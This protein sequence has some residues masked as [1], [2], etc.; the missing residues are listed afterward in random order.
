MFQR[1]QWKRAT[2]DYPSVLNLIETTSD[3]S[4]LLHALHAYV[5][6]GN[7]HQPVAIQRQIPIITGFS[8]VKTS[9]DSKTDSVELNL[10]SSKKWQEIACKELANTLQ[11]FSQSNL[12][13]EPVIT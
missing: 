1:L 8:H 4:S 11:P 3:V 2:L 13:Y 5:M 6:G 10:V 7:P 9:K 12:R